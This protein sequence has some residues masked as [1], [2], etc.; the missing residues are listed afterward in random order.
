M[1]KY[2]TKDGKIITNSYG[3]DIETGERS[4]NF[5]ITK[6]MKEEYNVKTGSSSSFRM[7]GL[8]QA[9][10]TVCGDETIEP[11]NKRIK[12]TRKQSKTSKYSIIAPDEYSKW[13]KLGFDGTSDKC[14]ISNAVVEDSFDNKKISDGSFFINEKTQELMISLENYKTNSIYNLVV[15]TRGGKKATKEVIL[16]I[17]KIDDDSFTLPC[18]YS[19]NPSEG[20]IVTQ[21][22]VPDMK[23]EQWQKAFD[24]IFNIASDD[25]KECP[26]NQWYKYQ[27]LK[28][29]KGEELKS[30]ESQF[31]DWTSEFSSEQSPKTKDYYFRVGGKSLKKKSNIFSVTVTKCGAEKISLAQSLAGKEVKTYELGQNIYTAGFFI[32]MANSKDGFD[33]WFEVTYNAETNEK[34]G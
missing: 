15:T 20:V 27:T 19:V 29:S 24:G 14:I 32:E 4:P 9:S 21:T 10:I 18:Q 34:C 33:S 23:P 12:I 13:F 16:D 1:I 11:I 31:N 30:L 7:S 3:F 6:P 25:E 22:D 2:K 8:V 17:K 5:E 28:D 26:I